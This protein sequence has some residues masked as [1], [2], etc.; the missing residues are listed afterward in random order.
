[1][2]I[3]NILVFSL[4]RTVNV[5]DSF[6]S[7]WPVIEIQLIYWISFIR[8]LNL[9]RLYSHQIYHHWMHAT[10]VR[11]KWNNIKMLSTTFVSFCW[12]FLCRQHIHVCS[13][14]Q[15]QW[16]C[17][18]LAL[19]WCWQLCT[20]ICMHFG[21]IWLSRTAKTFSEWRIACFN[22]WI[23]ASCWRNDSYNSIGSVDKNHRRSEWKII[24][25]NI[26]VTD[27]NRIQLK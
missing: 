3:N 27:L 1:M 10:K 9:M 8:A 26:F 20:D 7:M 24:D 15:E 18:P 17:R 2:K 22:Y 19:I 13:T 16:T 23:I 14:K 4:P 5:V 12:H 25:Q 6:C 11:H 21:C